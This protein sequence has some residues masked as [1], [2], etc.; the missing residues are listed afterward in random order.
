MKKIYLALFLSFLLFSGFT[1]NQIW[2]RARMPFNVHAGDKFTIEITINKLDLQH[3][4]DFKQKLPEGFLAMER[5][6]GGADFNF[7][8]QVVKFTWLR[9]PRVPTIT[10]SYDVIVKENVKGQFTLPGQFTYIYKNQRGTAILNDDKINVYPKGVAFS[11]NSQIQAGNLS[12]PPKDPRIVQCLRLKPTYSQRDNAMI[13]KLLVS[14]GSIPSAAKIEEIIPAGYFPGLIDSKNATFTFEN[15]K[16]EFIWKKMPDQKNFEISYKLVPLKANTPIPVIS[17]RLL[18]FSQ[19]KDYPVPIYEI[20]PE[21][22]NNNNN[23][24]K[25]EIYDFFKK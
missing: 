4:A 7:S 19:G 20:E 9:L 13:V 2:V 3:F 12:F 21:M 23:K 16:V 17:G 5:Q 22:L 15:N 10:L 6:S 8:N 18:Y 1:D 25:N 24:D 14:S 11:D